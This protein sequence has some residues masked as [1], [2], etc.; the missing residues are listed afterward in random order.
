[1]HEPSGGRCKR[2]A[3]PFT[4]LDS[5]FSEYPFAPISMKASLSPDTKRK[6]KA[7][8]NLITFFHKNGNLCAN[9]CRQ[10]ISVQSAGTA[11]GSLQR[12]DFSKS[13]SKLR[14]AANPTLKRGTARH[15]VSHCRPESLPGVLNIRCRQLGSSLKLHRACQPIFCRTSLPKCL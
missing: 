3:L 12:T 11:R 13:V 14:T 7:N 1:M 4:T 6:R 9:V 10:T 2:D 5:D 8:A 15:P